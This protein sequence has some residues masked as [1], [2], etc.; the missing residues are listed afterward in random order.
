M[1]G[2]HTGVYLVCE[3]EALLKSFDIEKK[4]CSHFFVTLARAGPYI[5]S[6]RFYL[7]LVIMLLT[8]TH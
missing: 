2:C 5:F 1:S 7:L 3:L 8:M 6:T 4:V